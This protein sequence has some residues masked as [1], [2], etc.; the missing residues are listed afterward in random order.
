MSLACVVSRAPSIDGV[1]T[2]TQSGR[3]ASI[4]GSRLR[5]SGRLFR[6][7]MSGL[8]WFK[9]RSLLFRAVFVMTSL[10][11][12]MLRSVSNVWLLTY[13]GAFVMS[14]NVFDWKACNILVLDGLLQPHSS[15][16]VLLWFY[17]AAVCFPL[18]VERIFRE[19]SNIS[20]LLGWVAD[21]C[22]YVGLPCQSLI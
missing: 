9:L 1:P 16:P 21:F 4:L 7:A 3:L 20:W 11:Y 5:S 19:A 17:T 14:R 13:H 18:T 6:L 2:V 12:G 8:W 22:L 10:M 15:I